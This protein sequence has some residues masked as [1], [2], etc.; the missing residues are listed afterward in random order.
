MSAR[1]HGTAAHGGKWHPGMKGAGP[2]RSAM[3]LAP[4]EAL[5]EE[6]EDEDE[7]DEFGELP[8]PVFDGGSH[9]GGV[10]GL[11][12]CPTTGLVA[13]GCRD[14]TVG[15][16]R[17]PRESVG[18]LLDGHNDEE[19]DDE[20]CWVR[21]VGFSPDGAVLATGGADGRVA[22]W[23][24]DGDLLHKFRLRSPTQ[25]EKRRHHPA[26]HPHGGGAL[27]GSASHPEAHGADHDDDSDREP[28]YVLSLCW[29]RNNTLAVG[30]AAPELAL[31]KV[32]YTSRYK[33]A[34]LSRSMADHSDSVR[35]L[36]P[37]PAPASRGRD[38]AFEGFF[39]KTKDTRRM[40]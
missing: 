32:D 19:D 30:G 7:D 40:S 9:V 6:D 3:K 36:A 29:V 16:W 34:R 24:A 28:F 14:G 31:W 37:S 25:L 20:G 5:G 1:S 12:W 18:L 10:T 38:G 39:E 15:L 22:V 17:D 13:T 27:L 26:A 8:R 35:C 11:A 21:A 2:Q 23:T 4:V 33:S